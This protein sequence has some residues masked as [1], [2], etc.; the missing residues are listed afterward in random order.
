LSKIFLGWTRKNADP[1]AYKDML[2]ERINGVYLPRNLKTSPLCGL[3]E[4]H[5]STPPGPTR[6]SCA[7]RS[8]GNVNAEGSWHFPDREI[9]P[10]QSESG[11]P[12]SGQHQYQKLGCRKQ[13]AEEDGS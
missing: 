11:K 4:D 5:I 2:A 7:W 6:R 10:D 9:V 1:S 13:L 3:V 8:K 12:D